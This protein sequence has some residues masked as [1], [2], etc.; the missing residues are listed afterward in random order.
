MLQQ[1]FFLSSEHWENIQN[2]T[3]EYEV[4]RNNNGTWTSTKD[5]TIESL[6]NKA[7]Q[8]LNKIPSKYNID[9]LLMEKDL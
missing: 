7:K 4:F 6:A 3:A 2:G 5:C 1:Y 9:L 8:D